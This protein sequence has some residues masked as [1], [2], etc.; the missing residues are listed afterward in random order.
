MVIPNVCE[1]FAVFKVL[2][3]K[4]VTFHFLLLPSIFTTV[5]PTARTIGI[6]AFE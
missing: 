5:S 4:I 1:H 6:S 2:H 3:L